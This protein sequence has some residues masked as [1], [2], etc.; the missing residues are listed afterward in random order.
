MFGRPLIAPLHEGTDGRGRGVEN[1]DAVALAKLP[2][3]VLL[4]PVGGSLIHDDGRAVG[5]RAIDDVRMPGDPADVGGA[6][7]NVVVF[8]V[9]NLLRRRRTADDVAAGRVDD[10]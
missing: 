4:R 10:T 9:E 8:Q 6:P 1:G 7:E 5:E 2:E 3:A